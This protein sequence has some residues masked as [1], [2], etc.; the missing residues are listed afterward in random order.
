[1]FI[2]FDFA[3][4]TLFLQAVFFFL[5]FLL[6]RKLQPFPVID[7]FIVFVLIGFNYLLANCGVLQKFAKK[8]EIQDGVK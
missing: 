4:A 5:D 2:K 6:M 8:Y 7:H 1:L 3:L